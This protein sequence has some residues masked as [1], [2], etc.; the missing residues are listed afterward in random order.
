MLRCV[1]LVRTDISEERI[2]SIIRVTYCC[3][4]GHVGAGT[5]WW[6]RRHVPLKHRFLQERHSVTSQK[7]VFFIV[8]A[9]KTSNFTCNIPSSKSH[10]HILL[11]CHYKQF[12]WGH[13]SSLN[14]FPSW[15]LTLWLY[16]GFLQLLI[17]YICRYHLYLKTV[18]FSHILRMH[19]AM[20]KTGLLNIEE[21]CLL[22]CYAMWLL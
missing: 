18:S 5:P 8:N 17:Q 4:V 20:V 2:A 3:P 1:A 10:V 7:T 21:W 19:R 13:C 9:M 16:V 22:G 14:P 6:E 11:L 12:V 15:M